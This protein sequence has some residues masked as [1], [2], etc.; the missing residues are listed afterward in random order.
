[1][2][3]RLCKEFQCLPSALD[4]EDVVQLLDILELRAYAYAKEIVDRP[5]MD[6]ESIERH[7]I[8]DRLVTQVMENTQRAAQWR[9]ERDKQR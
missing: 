2:I 5:D 9:L 6:E 3:S 8:P 1:M 7:G 4:N